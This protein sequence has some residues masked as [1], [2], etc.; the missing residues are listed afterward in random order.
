[1]KAADACAGF[2]QNG[3][4]CAAQGRVD[5]EYPHHER[6]THPVAVEKPPE[7]GGDFAN[8]SPHSSRELNVPLGA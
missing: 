5:G 4:P 6:L 3:I 1:M 8:Q 2:L 7:E